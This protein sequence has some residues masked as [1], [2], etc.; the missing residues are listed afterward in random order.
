MFQL[1]DNFANDPVFAQFLNCIEDLEDT[2]EKTLQ[3][4]ANLKEGEAEEGSEHDPDNTI[5]VLNSKITSAED[6]L[7]SQ[8]DR[9]TQS[10]GELEYEVKNLSVVVVLLPLYTV[11]KT[12][13]HE[14]CLLCFVHPSSPDCKGCA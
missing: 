9:L 5:S 6:G 7:F 10:V 12:E 8:I 14:Y 3:M 11:E 1:Q 2:A 4:L 13:S